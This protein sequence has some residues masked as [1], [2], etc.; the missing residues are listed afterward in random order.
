M[1]NLHTFF[2]K[3]NHLFFN[4]WLK[5]FAVNNAYLMVNLVFT[6]GSK[7]MLSFDL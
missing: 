6:S 3:K 5:Y 2:A 7:S 1:D 4:R